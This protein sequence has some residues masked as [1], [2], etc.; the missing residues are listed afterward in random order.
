M[1][2]RLSI[3]ELETLI[4]QTFTQPG[5]WEGRNDL[6]RMLVTAL[7]KTDPGLAVRTACSADP[8]Q[9]V[10]PNAGIEEA[11]FLWTTA[12]PDQ[13]VEWLKEMQRKPA[14]SNW[15]AFNQYQAAVA[16]PLILSD[17]PLAHE[18]IML[19][20]QTYPGYVIRDAIHMLSER[21]L[22]NK[23]GTDFMLDAFSK[24]LPWIREF[25]PEKRS[26]STM[27]LER[28]DV[29]NGF[30]FQLGRSPLES[31]LPG[32]I[33][34]TVDLLPA[35]RRM[36]AESHAQA[37]LGTIYNTRPRPDRNKVESAARDWL[38]TH[39]PEAAEEIFGQSLSTATKQ[40]RWQ[41]EQQMKNL[42]DREVIRDSDIIQTLERQYFSEFPEFIPQA[43]EHAGRIKDPVKRAEMINQLQKPTR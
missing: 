32:R 43:L 40:G 12:E 28:R 25:I 3:E 33:M 18:V 8:Q 21:S 19:S 34:E 23:D 20:E 39:L 4:P 11:I 7:A 31:P 6:L 27:G 36:I 22:D 10:I 41:I 14:G 29:I 42:T 37:M 13:A 38:K 24:F 9:P 35:E 15:H 30:L 26:R 2:A 1:V 17:S 16:A 5:P